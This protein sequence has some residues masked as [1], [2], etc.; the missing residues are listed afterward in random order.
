M[1]M[2]KAELKSS[3]AYISVTSLFFVITLF[4]FPPYEIYLTNLSEFAFGLDLFWWIPLVTGLAVMLFLVG[5]GLLVHLFFKRN[6]SV[7]YGTFLFAIGMACY[8]QGNFLSLK[9]GLLTGIPITWSHYLREI[10]INT[11]LWGSIVFMVLLLLYVFK[12]RMEKIAKLVCIIFVAMQAVAFGVLL[13][14]PDTRVTSRAIVSTKG[15]HEVSSQRNVVVFVLDMFDA[16]YFEQL[17]EKEPDFKEQFADFTYFS[18]SV[19]S[20]STTKYSIGALLTGQHLLNDAP[21]WQ[22][23][24]DNAGTETDFW[25]VLLENQYRVEMYTTAYHVP[26]NLLRNAYNYVE[27]T[28]AIADHKT[29]LRN[30]YQ[31]SFFK[32][33]PD[34]FKPLLWLDGTEFRKALVTRDDTG[35]GMD[36][37]SDDNALF[38]SRM[39]N[40]HFTLNNETNI[41]KFIHLH[42][43]H[44]PYATDENANHVV[45]AN[46]LQA[47]KGSV[48]IVM[49]YL[50]NMK[51]LGAYDQSTIIICADHGYVGYCELSNPILLV[52]KA[53]ASGAMQISDAPV[54]HLDFHAT[55][56]DDLG[57]NPNHKYGK[58]V[59]EIEPGETRNRLYYQYILMEGSTNGKYRLFEYQVADDSNDLERAFSLTDR[60]YT[61]DGEI[62][63][64]RINCAT[65]REAG[66][67]NVHPGELPRELQ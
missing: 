17:L 41:L 53:G 64:H 52:K 18:N 45:G 67:P 35:E 51:D 59:F 25:D 1:T 36:V 3:V 43:V 24:L 62:I 54:S 60:E 16:R 57:L 48:K 49:E 30:L 20:G 65:C 27:T 58:S 12:D 26:N 21:S 14:S 23:M 66:Y 39:Q 38:F 56:M 15:I 8:V 31:L 22:Q 37:F 47:A 13:F 44:Y 34:V 10:T 2:Q 28:T 46:A 32:Y 19:G 11:A 7:F 29:L 50:Q 63:P 9:I 6:G 4:V 5:L 55:I 33:A 61:V 42:G 40:S